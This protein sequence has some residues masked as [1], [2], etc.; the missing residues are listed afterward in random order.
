MRDETKKQNKTDLPC[1]P[2]EE[3]Y[4][5]RVKTIIKSLGW[6]KENSQYR[7]LAANLEKL[8]ANL[9]NELGAIVKLLDGY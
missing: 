7:G 2:F 8:L 3:Y 5:S 1:I 4:Q 6:H 9:P